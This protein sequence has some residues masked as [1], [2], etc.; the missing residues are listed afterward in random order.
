M[1]L[2]LVLE[3]VPLAAQSRPFL[4]QLDKNSKTDD[5]SA[6]FCVLACV[7]IK[8]NFGGTI[9][10]ALM[11]NNVTHYWNVLP[12]G[13]WVDATRSQFDNDIYP[14]YVLAD[15]PE[16]VYWFED[17]K[18]KYNAFEKELMKQY[19]LLYDRIN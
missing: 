1:D 11:S 4:A 14:T 12:S 8:R 2:N 15:C 13:A 9:A 5:P 10:R 19:N 16:H 7:F 3:A 17:T 18:N 6:G